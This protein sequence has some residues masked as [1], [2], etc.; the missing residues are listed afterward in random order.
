MSSGQRVAPPKPDADSL[1]S[2]LRRYATS[3]HRRAAI[4]SGPAEAMAAPPAGGHM[5]GPSIGM[6]QWWQRG[7]A[8]GRGVGM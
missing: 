3:A 2:R 1:G 6:P 7:R 4:T 5:P 8:S